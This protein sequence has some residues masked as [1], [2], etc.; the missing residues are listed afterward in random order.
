[1]KMRAI[2]VALALM[3]FAC[4]E[5]QKP[6]ETPP[7]SLESNPPSSTPPPASSGGPVAPTN[8]DDVKKGIAALKA[9]D[10]PG[11]KAA[12]DAAIAKNPKQADAYHYRGVVDMETHGQ[13]NLET[14]E[15]YRQLAA[16]TQ[17]SPSLEGRG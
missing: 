12:F 1:M 11:A 15:K 14:H 8:S 13:F 9:G 4:G 3:L 7:P 17:T 5:T 2:P 6:P 16:R 10:L